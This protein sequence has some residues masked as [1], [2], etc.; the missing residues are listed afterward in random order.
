MRLIAPKLTQSLLRP[1]VLPNRVLQLGLDHVT[2]P[3]PA[4]FILMR[5]DIRN[6]LH[7]DVELLGLGFGLL[8]LLCHL[9]DFLGEVVQIDS[10]LLL[11]LISWGCSWHIKYFWL[12]KYFFSIIIIEF[13]ACLYSPTY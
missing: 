8:A 9:L 2:V 10:S 1:R 5:H 13:E 6:P 7:L 11:E 12:R 3:A 4:V